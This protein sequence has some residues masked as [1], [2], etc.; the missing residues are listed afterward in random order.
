M[1]LFDMCSD[2]LYFFVLLAMFCCTMSLALTPILYTSQE[3][4]E[5]GISWSLWSIFGNIP[6]AALE[7]AESLP[8]LLRCLSLLLLYVL[9]LGSNVLLANLLIALMNNTYNR[10]QEASKTH[11]AYSQAEAV[12]EF[13]DISP[14]P[15]PLN[16]FNKL[17]FLVR[18][19]LRS[20][21]GED[22]A[23][24]DDLESGQ[25]V[26]SP[27]RKRSKVTVNNKH[28]GEIKRKVVHTVTATVKL[29]RGVVTSPQST[30]NPVAQP[31]LTPLPP[32]RK[33]R[34]SSSM[35]SEK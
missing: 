33:A 17:L 16:L 7:R 13:D 20:R 25:E 18:C 21:L 31:G 6:H 5:V 14:L 11:W 30:A 19:K 12:L 23:N 32:D 22:T 26:H 34:T 29:E 2:A 3:R 9:A 24:T 1:T 8:L 35:N 27:V 28:L 4:A 10:Y 15:S